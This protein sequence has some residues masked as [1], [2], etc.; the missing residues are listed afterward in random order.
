[1]TTTPET[2]TA[3]PFVPRTRSLRVL[4]D[5]ASECRGC[6]LYRAATHTVFGDGQR[7]ARI[8]LVGEQPGDREDLAGKPFVGPAGRVLDQCLEAAGVDRSSVYLT[9][10]VKHFKHEQRGKRRIHQRP[11][12]SEIEACN[13]WLAAELDLVDPAVVVAL[14]AT[15][16]RSLS[17]RTVPIGRN[18]GQPIVLDGRPMIVTYHPSAVLRGDERA[19][20]IRAAL[21]DDLRLAANLA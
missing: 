16:A 3:A 5:A 18:R 8:V 20:A 11:T 12:T 9:N 4:A 10:A 13:P 6:S 19:S 7:D 21:V 2:A 14:G 15:A 17:G 1:M